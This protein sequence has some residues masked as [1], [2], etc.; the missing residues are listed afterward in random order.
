[1]LRTLLIQAGVFLAPFAAYALYLAVRRREVKDAGNWTTP[2]LVWC[3]GLAV[4]LTAASLLI[5]T[6]FD[7]A[8]AGS[9]YVPPHVEDGRVVPGHFE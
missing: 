9:T 4:V 1:M 6:Q 5:L 7:R 2:V 3:G 8:P